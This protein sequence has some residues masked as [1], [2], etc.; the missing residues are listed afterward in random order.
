MRKSVV[1]TAAVFFAAFAAPAM[2]QIAFQPNK[3]VGPA[4]GHEAPLETQPEQASKVPEQQQPSSQG[5]QQQERP[6][7]AEQRASGQ[8]GQSRHEGEANDCKVISIS[9]PGLPSKMPSVY[10]VTILDSQAGLVHDLASCNEKADVRQFRSDRS[11]AIKVTQNTAGKA[12]LSIP[13]E[14]ANRLICR[15]TTTA[16]NWPLKERD[17]NCGGTIGNR[18]AITLE[19]GAPWKQAKGN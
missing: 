7:Q 19:P 16:A 8:Q 15:F 11:A 18:A 1:L 3:V 10:S 2:A 5:A 9:I 17:W 12:Y 6:P 14:R 13:A 4:P